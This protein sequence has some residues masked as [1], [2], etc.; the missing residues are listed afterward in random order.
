LFREVRH[1]ESKE[2]NLPRGLLESREGS[3]S[4]EHAADLER[5]LG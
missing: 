3:I 2:S 5:R 1:A 4:N